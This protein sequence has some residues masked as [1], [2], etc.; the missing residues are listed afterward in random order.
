MVKASF[1]YHGQV[2]HLENVKMEHDYLCII[3]LEKR[4]S[5][6]YSYRI[7]RYK[8]AKITDFRFN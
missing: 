4:I 2:R 8:T 6:K 1:R 5:G 3:G 7:K